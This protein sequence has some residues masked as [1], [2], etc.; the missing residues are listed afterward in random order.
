MIIFLDKYKY[1]KII[2]NRIIFK[3]ILRKIEISYI[4]YVNNISFIKY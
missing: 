3:K 1:D 2:K 4:K